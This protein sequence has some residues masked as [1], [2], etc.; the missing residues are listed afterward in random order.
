MSNENRESAI[1]KA[2][3][4]LTK[5][6]LHAYK[7]WCGSEKPALAPSLN[8]K[9]FN[10]F[11]N[12]KTCEEIRRLNPTLQLG[13]IVAA[14]V[15][16]RWDERREDHLDNLLNATSTRVQQ[17]TLETADFVC[18]LLAVANREHGDR[19]RQYLQSG[20]PDDLGE[21]RIQNLTGLKM[22][23]ETLQKLTGQDRQQV[24]TQKGLVTVQ[25]QPAD[26]IMAAGRAPAP[27]EAAAALKLL[28]GR[29][30]GN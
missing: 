19:L 25:H 3:S 2:T 27:A 7:V 29:S 22:V 26:S 10:L 18:D 11:L 30:P 15:A 14:R 4:Y 5:R 21:F 6:E 12:G 28:L 1:E 17:T 8:A 13:E 23:I 24:V 16:G 9:L 20:N